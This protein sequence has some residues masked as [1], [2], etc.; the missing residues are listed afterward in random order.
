V[1]FDFN[2]INCFVGVYFRAVFLAD[3]QATGPMGDWDYS[4]DPPPVAVDKI[5]SPAQ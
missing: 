1:T 5:Y 3:V 4:G 2:D